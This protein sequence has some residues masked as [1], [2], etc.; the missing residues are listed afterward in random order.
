MAPQFSRYSH[1]SPSTIPAVI[2]FLSLSASFLYILQLYLS[3]PHRLLIGRRGLLR[4]PPLQRRRFV[5]FCRQLRRF[6]VWLKSWKVALWVSMWLKSTPPPTHT[7]LK[8]DVCNKLWEETH[9]EWFLFR[10]YRAFFYDRHLYMSHQLL[11]NMT[12]QGKCDFQLNTR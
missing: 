9:T 6:W 7:S 4:P 11:K 2:F 3:F 1:L 5:Y 10:V 12:T 8:S